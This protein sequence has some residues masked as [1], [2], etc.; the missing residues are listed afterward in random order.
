MKSSGARKDHAQPGVTETLRP[1][2]TAIKAALLR[3]HF[4]LKGQLAR[5]YLRARERYLVLRADSDPRR[6]AQGLPV[7]P[8]SLRVLVAGVPELDRFLSTGR[9]QAT[10]FQ[11]VLAGVGI[12]L[13]D[14]DAIL[15]FGCGCGRIARW[16]SH[17]PHTRIEGCDYNGKVIDWCNA[18]LPFMHARKT[19][20]EPPL[21]YRDAS[22]DFLYAFSV[23]THMSVEL[24]S[25]WMTEIA[26]VVKP[27]GLMWFTLHGE[28]YRKRLLPEQRTRFD[29]G[30]I[31]VWLPEVQGTNFC[32]AYWPRPAVQRMLGDRFEVLVRFD[33]RA[34]A[35]LAKRMNLDHDA[36]LVR[37]TQP[38]TAG[39]SRTARS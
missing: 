39:A 14:M 21:P 26:R 10:Y 38:D 20:L 1:C 15:D 35:E 7:P 9:A 33:P 22:F 24:A 11:E 28:S 29:A 27:G 13:E 18:N 23:F 6:T 31:V 36:Y 8:A 3:A 30:E 5:G 34:E 25:A 2:R 32:G 4:P 19:A 12:P 17:L 37:R 16:Y